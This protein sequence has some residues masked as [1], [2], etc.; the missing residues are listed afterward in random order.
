M[1]RGWGVGGGGYIFGGLLTRIKKAFS[2]KLAAFIKIPFAFKG[3]F[4]NRELKLKHL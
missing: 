1:K 3:F 2:N 4:V